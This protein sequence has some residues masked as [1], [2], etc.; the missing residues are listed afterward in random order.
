LFDRLMKQENSIFVT[1]DSLLESTV[2]K[3]PRG[4]ENKTTRN[5]LTEGDLPPWNNDTPSVV[6]T[7]EPSTDLDSAHP[8]EQAYVEDEDDIS[9]DEADDEPF[10]KKTIALD[11][12]VQQDNV[13]EPEEQDAAVTEFS[14][15][16]INVPPA[17]EQIET[18]EVWQDTPDVAQATEYEQAEVALIHAG[19]DDV[20]N[21]PQRQFVDMAD[22][23]AAMFGHGVNDLSNVKVTHPQIA[24]YLENGDKLLR[25]KQINKWSDFIEELGVGGLNK[26]LL[27]QSNL[28]QHGEHFIVRIDE[29]NKHLDEEQ[30]RTTI[31]DALSAF[32]QK[33]VAF[34]VQYG[35]VDETPFKIQQ[36]ISLIRHQYAHSV[37]QTNDS[38]QEL[39]KAFEGRIIEGSIKPR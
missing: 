15:H 6:I 21:Q 7:S 37:V 39:I 26:Q 11:N 13:V 30:H 10:E 14:E 33:P 34:E 1:N 2:K 17:S 19:Q 5:P 32:Y 8:P 9:F 22:E 27:L 38:I 29:R 23:I 3:G 4:L 36:Q 24:P 28:V 20:E 12:N 25:A 16:T 31:T 18:N 35:E